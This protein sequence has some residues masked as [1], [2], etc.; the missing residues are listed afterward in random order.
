MA[1][2]KKYPAVTKVT[3]SPKPHPEV[4]GAADTKNWGGK[5]GFENARELAEKDPVIRR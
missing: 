3:A 2:E 1:R 5:P 4:R